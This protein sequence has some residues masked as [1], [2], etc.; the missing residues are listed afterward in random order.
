MPGN[1]IA[2]PNDTISAT[3]VRVKFKSLI[4]RLSAG[5][6]FHITKHNKVLASLTSNRIDV[7]T[8]I[9][10]KSTVNV[11]ND[12][13]EEEA[14]YNAT[15]DAMDQ[16]SEDMN[17]VTPDTPASTPGFSPSGYRLD[18]LTPITP[19]D[20][21]M[22]DALADIEASEEVIDEVETSEADIVDIEAAT[23]VTPVGDDDHLDT[24]TMKELHSFANKHNITI[25]P[26][27]RKSEV[28]AAIRADMVDMKID[29]HDW[30][31]EEHDDDYDA[32][33]ADLADRSELRRQRR[34]TTV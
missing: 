12:D 22:S 21:A 13:T 5:E 29:D 6:T 20:A 19:E 9:T 3:A 31:D 33:F 8:P 24:L 4:A 1:V 30:L 23:P 17:P 15:N 34:N 32:F 7:L 25:P 16:L 11:E 28:K 27:S 14:A 10:P 18:T 2:T 26:R